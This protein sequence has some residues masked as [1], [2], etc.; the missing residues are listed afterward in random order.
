MGRI[1]TWGEELEEH[2]KDAPQRL[3]PA[4]FAGVTARLKS[5]PDKA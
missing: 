4:R 1:A 2:G 3:K 5:C